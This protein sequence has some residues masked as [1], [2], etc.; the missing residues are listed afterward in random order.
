M[1]GPCL[2]RLEGLLLYQARN[3]HFELERVLLTENSSG[4]G[5]LRVQ[6]VD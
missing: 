2:L 4:S 1:H 5:V 3:M 6:L